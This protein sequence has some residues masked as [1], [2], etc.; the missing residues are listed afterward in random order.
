[1]YK[2]KSV[3]ARY[4]DAAQKTDDLS[5]RLFYQKQDIKEQIFYQQYL[6]ELAKE[7]A[8]YVLQHLSATADVSKAIQEIDKLNESINRLGGK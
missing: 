7:V 4:Q 6:Q 5:M 8:P 1:M 2:Y 3:F